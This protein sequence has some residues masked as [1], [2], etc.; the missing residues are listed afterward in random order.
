MA[1]TLQNESVRTILRSD[2]LLL[3][4]AKLGTR[5]SS[6]SPSALSMLLFLK[7]VAPLPPAMLPV[8]DAVS[9][10]KCSKYDICDVGRSKTEK[11]T[12]FYFQSIDLAN[13]HIVLN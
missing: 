4:L 12:N 6:T 10:K 11:Q 9:F 7:L 13:F 2:R 8:V 1:K 5:L 3:L